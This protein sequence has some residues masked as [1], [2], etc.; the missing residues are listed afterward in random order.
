MEKITSGSY[1]FEGDEESLISY[2]SEL[3]DFNFTKQNFGVLGIDDARNL[4]L[5]SIE[6]EES[7]NH[8]HILS[9]SGIQSEAQNALLKL[10]EE[11]KENYIFVL[12]IPNKKDLLGTLLS[13]FQTIEN[14]KEKTH[15]KHAKN[16]LNL[17]LLERL[18]FVEKFLKENE[19][20]DS[21]R[22]LVSDFYD[23]LIQILKE[24]KSLNKEEIQTY[25]SLKPLVHTRGSSPKIILEFLAYSLPKLQ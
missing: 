18:S 11:P 10:F 3:G 7:K 24:K 15:T 19:D 2:L 13:R 4:K 5:S 17:N 22:S 6:K 21:T 20:N 23:S 14:P 8:V 12:V 25:I 16:F 9:V 1:I